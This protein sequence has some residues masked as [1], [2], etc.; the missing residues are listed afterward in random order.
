[1]LS[2]TEVKHILAEAGLKITVQRGAIYR[3]LMESNSHPSA[4]EVFEQLR[5]KYPS[6]SLGTV[7]K[8]FEAFSEAGLIRRVKTEDGINRYDAY[9]SHH[10]HLYCSRTNKIA[11]FDD[12]ELFSMIEHYLAK[13]RIENFRIQDFQLSINGEFLEDNP[14]NQ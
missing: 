5:E 11:D 8:T 14:N 9:L 6:I 13:K 12:P 1:M 4:E 7:Y 2:H 10:S 3:L